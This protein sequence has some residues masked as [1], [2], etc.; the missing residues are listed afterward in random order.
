M[1]LKWFTTHDCIKIPSLRAFNN[2]QHFD[3]E[4]LFGTFLDSTIAQDDTNLNING[5]SVL[6]ADHPSNSKRGGVF[7]YFEK[8]F[9]LKETRPASHFFNSYSRN[10]PLS[11]RGLNFRNF[12]KKGGRSDFLLKKGGFGKTGNRF[13]KGNITYFHTNPFQCFLSLNV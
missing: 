11:R 9:P 3:I 6:R 10:P 8:S 1:E 2:A 7:M 5:Y 12:R 13:E 4:F